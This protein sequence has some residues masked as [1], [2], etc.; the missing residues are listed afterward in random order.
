MYEA[1]QSVKACADMAS[2][3]DLHFRQV[4]RQFGGIDCVRCPNVYGSFGGAYCV[5]CARRRAVWRDILCVLPDKNGILAG[6][7]VCTALTLSGILAKQTVCTALTLPIAVG[8]FMLLCWNLYL[9]FSNLTTIEY[10]EGVSACIQVSNRVTRHALSLL[11]FFLL[12]TCTASETSIRTC[13]RC[14]VL[15]S[16]LRVTVMCLL[17]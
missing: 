5:Y 13:D 14:C 3:A 8:L 15:E 16:M 10:H 1:V 12:C 11:A 2:E 9:I 17:L 4:H 6:Q 7:T